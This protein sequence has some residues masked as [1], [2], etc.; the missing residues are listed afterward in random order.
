M[1]EIKKLLFMI[2]KIMPTKNDSFKNLVDFKEVMDELKIPFWLDSGLVL[3]LHRDGDVI[4][5]D[6][7]DTDICMWKD[8]HAHKSL[9]FLK[10]LGEKGFTLLHDWRFV[11]GTSEGIGI[12]RN[13]NK[14]DIIMMH[15]KKNEYGDVAFYLAR[16]LSGGMGQMPYFAF[17]FPGELYDE[18][19]NIKW[20][21]VSFMVP[22][23]IEGYLVARYGPDWRIPIYRSKGDQRWQPG[24]PLWNPCHRTNWKYDDPKDV[25]E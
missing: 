22:K 17:V 1:L 18:L 5:G 4:D 3:G 16:N 2:I 12:K 10:K 19:N 23:N 7:D 14:I 13:G 24:N 6:E 25:L 11:N 8:E 20:H 15:R 9:I 21:D